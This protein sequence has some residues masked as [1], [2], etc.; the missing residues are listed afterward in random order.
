MRA[1]IIHQDQIQAL[2]VRL[3]EIVQ[4]AL[5][6]RGR[7]RGKLHDV[8]GTA[9][10]FHRPKHPGI[11]ERVLVNADRFDPTCGDA[12]A[13]D[14]VQAEPT[15]ITRPDPH[16][17][18]IGIRKGIPQLGHKVRFEIGDGRRVFFGLVGRGTLGLAPSL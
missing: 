17:L 1:G 13:V 9:E 7:E 18:L 15:L 16:R 4:K 2:G 8:A 14:G 12:V 5:D 10:R 6:H 11:L 3:G